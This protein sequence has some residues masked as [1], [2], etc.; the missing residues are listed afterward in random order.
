MKY[1]DTQKD[2]K[3]ISY[4]KGDKLRFYLFGGYYTTFYTETFI[5]FDRT[6]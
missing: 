2:G 5:Y 4:E 6:D 1:R 3:V